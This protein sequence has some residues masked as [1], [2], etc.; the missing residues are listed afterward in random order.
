MFC[1]SGRMALSTDVLT[2]LTPNIIAPYCPSLRSEATA[3][4]IVKQPRIGSL[5]PVWYIMPRHCEPVV[6]DG[7]VVGQRIE[8]L[9][10]HF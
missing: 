6:Q 7:E 2:M 3:V 9:W 10:E 4:V 8:H 1:V 5:K